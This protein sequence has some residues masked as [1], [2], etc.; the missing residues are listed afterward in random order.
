MQRLVEMICEENERLVIFNAISERIEEMA[1]HSKGNF[2]L[3]ST[4]NIL[5]EQELNIAIEKLIPIIY[6]LT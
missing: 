6:E 3:L 5:R 4:L 2:V 1:R